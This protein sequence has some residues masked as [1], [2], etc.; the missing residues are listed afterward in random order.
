M[1]QFNIMI[2]TKGFTLLELLITMGILAVLASTVVL[3]FNPVEYL[4][5]SRDT[6][7]IGDLD[8]IS[9]AIDLYT[10]NKPAITEL[11]TAS[12]V[13][14]SLPDTS[15]T[16]GSYAL[17][18][19][20]SPWQYRCAT[21]ANLQKVDGTGWLPVNFSSIF[22]GAPLATLPIDPVNDNVNA[23]YYMFIASGRKYELSSIMESIR[24]MSGGYADKTSTDNGDDPARYEMGSNLLLA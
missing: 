16:C 21:S 24:Y 11:G 7:R 4:R 1:L 19:L 9:K 22:S 14:L 8:A 2:R 15:F 13:Y 20:P 3:V 23:Q 17:P 10:V 18:P 5:Q 12:V 6:R